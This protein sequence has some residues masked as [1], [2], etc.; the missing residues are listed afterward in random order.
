MV[1]AR[2]VLGNGHGTSKLKG[3]WGL[4]SSEEFLTSRYQALWRI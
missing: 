1:S 4:T 2:L 3:R